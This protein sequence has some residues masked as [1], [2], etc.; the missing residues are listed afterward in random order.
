MYSL[1]DNFSSNIKLFSSTFL[2]VDNIRRLVRVS[3]NIV[4]HLQEPVDSSR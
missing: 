3:V 1:L 4:N 2:T